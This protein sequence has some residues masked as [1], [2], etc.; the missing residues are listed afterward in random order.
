MVYWLK[1]LSIFRNKVYLQK[2]LA[3]FNDKVVRKGVNPKYLKTTHGQ[4]PN[5]G[6]LPWLCLL[7]IDHGL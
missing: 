6:L 2:F 1:D 7:E 4:L 5:I 3:L